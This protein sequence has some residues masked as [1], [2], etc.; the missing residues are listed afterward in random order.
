MVNTDYTVE[1]I[2]ELVEE[3]I[4]LGLKDHDNHGVKVSIHTGKVGVWIAEVTQHGSVLLDTCGEY[5][6]RGHGDTIVEALNDLNSR[7]RVDLA[8]D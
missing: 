6:M 7:C 3:L 4:M 5:V 1:W 2:N 8:V